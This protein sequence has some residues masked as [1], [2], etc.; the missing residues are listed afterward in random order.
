MSGRWEREC[1]PLCCFGVWVEA[2][3]LG[4]LRILEA[5]RVAAGTKGLPG[6]PV[7][8]LSWT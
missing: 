6:L 8:L 4:S 3:V 2:G 1:R 7:P 5:S